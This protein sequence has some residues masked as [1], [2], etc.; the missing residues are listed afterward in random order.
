MSKETIDKWNEQIKASN[1]DF[2]NADTMGKRVMIAKDVLAAIEAKRIKAKNGYYFNAPGEFEYRSGTV[3]K[4]LE[5]VD[6]QPC[7]ACALG[8]ILVA[9]VARGACGDTGSLVMAKDV[10]LSLSALFSFNE[11]AEIET[12]F[13]SRSAEGWSGVDGFGNNGSQGIFVQGR[14]I[15]YPK[16]KTFGN[17][18]G[19]AEKRLQAIMWNIIDGGGVFDPSRKVDLNSK[20]PT[21]V[22]EL[23]KTKTEAERFAYVEVYDTVPS[24]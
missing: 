21:W 2:E 10:S 15:K 1:V 14:I 13:E 8:S 5:L 9:S 11:L 6:E 18:Y 23:G 12:A 7:Q 20:V 3:A 16:A 19:S 24:K 17:R 22:D 4:K